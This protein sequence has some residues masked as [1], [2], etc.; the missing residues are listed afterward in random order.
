MK[1][2]ISAAARGEHVRGVVVANQG[3]NAV[4]AQGAAAGHH[5]WK[6]S[7]SRKDEL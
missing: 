6:N 1:L 2:L 7:L 3:V 5:Y 4:A